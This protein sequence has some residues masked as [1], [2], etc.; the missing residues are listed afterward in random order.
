LASRQ[1]KGDLPKVPKPILAENKDA[2]H[3][4]PVHRY[5]HFNHHHHLAEFI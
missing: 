1:G 3:L 5:D 4:D 2:G